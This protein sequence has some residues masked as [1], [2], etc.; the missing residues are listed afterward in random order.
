MNKKVVPYIESDKSKKEQVAEM[1]DTI[2]P[3]YDLL[4][5]L[6]SF[7]I[8]LYWKR[9]LI[10]SVMPLQEK[11]IL[12]VATGTGAVA[13][14]L[15]KHGAKDITGVDISSQMLQ[16]GRNKLTREQT[17]C[18]TLQQ[19]DAE[20]LPFD[21]NTFDAVT[22]AYGVRNFE[23]LEAGLAEI[24]RVL[25]PGAQL[26]VLEFSKP[27]VFPVKQ[28]FAFYSR[29]MLPVIGKLL[30]KD[31]RAYSYLPESVQQFPEGESFLRILQ[32]Q[33]FNHTQCKPLTFGIVSL[34]TAYK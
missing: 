21:A 22:V 33:G 14:G 2:S 19:A 34:Y 9:C 12:D 17:K 27:K 20:H 1:F 6:L 10:R 32:Q 11:K 18:I 29:Y 4:N 3:R 8:H 30:T 7:G 16:V 13:V 26:S 31:K 25:K 5:G 23:N 15:Y 24:R 28:L